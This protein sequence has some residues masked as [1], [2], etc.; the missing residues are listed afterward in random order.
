MRLHRA[1]NNLVRASIGNITESKTSWIMDEGVVWSKYKSMKPSLIL[2]LYFENIHFTAK[3]IFLIS[4]QLIWDSTVGKTK[5]FGILCRIFW[6]PAAALRNFGT[7][8]IFTSKKL[9]YPVAPKTWPLH[10]RF[11]TQKHPN[12]C[13]VEIIR[14]RIPELTF[15]F[16]SKTKE[17]VSRAQTQRMRIMQEVKCRRD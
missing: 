3:E 5:A 13:H 7:R 12:S 14:L 4:D 11:C 17:N 16:I 9:K 2:D 15:N 6:G 10:K 1:G 8:Y